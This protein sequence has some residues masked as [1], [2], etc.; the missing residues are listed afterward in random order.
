MSKG[1]AAAALASLSGI[2]EAGDSDGLFALVHSLIEKVVVLNGN[3]TIY[4]AF[5]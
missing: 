4:W 2:I 3:V 1:E 5:C